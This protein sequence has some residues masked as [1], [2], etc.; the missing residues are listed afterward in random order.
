MPGLSI[1]IKKEMSDSVSN[2]TFLLS[3]GVLMFL[4]LFSGYAAGK[5]FQQYISYGG[6]ETERPNLTLIAYLVP[7]INLLGALVTVVYGFNSI[8]KE[9]TEGSLKVML[10]YPIFRDQVMLGKLLAGLFIVSIVTIVSFALSLGVFLWFSNILLNPDMI[11]RFSIFTLLTI[12][13]LSSWLGLSMFLSQVFKDPKTTLLVMFLVV[14]LLNSDLFSY[15]GQIISHIVYGSAYFLVNGVVEYNAQLG[16][17][18]TFIY[19]LPPPQGYQI[20]SYNVAMPYTYTFIG[21]QMV[22]SPNE[23]W[24]VFVNYVYSIGILIVVPILT[25][26]GNYL[27]FTRKD[28]T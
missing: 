19:Y 26:V 20:V 28:I 5:Q 8:N 18:T 23:L 25:F 10:S 14:G 21:D 24:N 17:L 2:R 6:Y 16:A 12:L 13:L 3:L 9:R 22:Y 4:L 11:L 7:N 27:L 1:I 15:L